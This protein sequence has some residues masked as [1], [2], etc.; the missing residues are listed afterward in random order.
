M[1]TPRRYQDGARI[2]LRGRKLSRIIGRQRPFINKVRNIVNLLGR[3]SL[4]TEVVTDAVRVAAL[5]VA[6]LVGLAGRIPT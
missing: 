6:V 5:R 4:F 2:T 1:Q 3:Y